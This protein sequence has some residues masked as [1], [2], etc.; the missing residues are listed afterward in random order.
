[1]DV[2][3]IGQKKAT[4]QV[5]S[6]LPGSKLM[7]YFVAHEIPE[8]N[9]GMMTLLISP[10]VSDILESHMQPILTHLDMVAIDKAAADSGLNDDEKFELTTKMYEQKAGVDLDAQVKE[11]MDQIADTLQNAEIEWLQI[12]DQVKDLPDEE[13]AKKMD[14]LTADRLKDLV[15]DIT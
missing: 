2:S 3:L 8:E 5:Q 9:L 4:T 6:N 14:E 12:V 15:K 13:A 1:M 7:A 11:I 10:L